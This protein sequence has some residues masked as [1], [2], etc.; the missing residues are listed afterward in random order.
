M[1]ISKKNLAA[2]GLIVFTAAVIITLTV[3][4]MSTSYDTVA[5]A[6]GNY[7]GALI[8]GGD[9]LDDEFFAGVKFPAIHN[10]VNV[11]AVAFEDDELAWVTVGFAL[12]KDAGA[13]NFCVIEN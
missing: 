3:A 6:S 9:V 2:I 5:L 10:V 11:F 4:I 8:S 12:S 13:H 7:S 1:K